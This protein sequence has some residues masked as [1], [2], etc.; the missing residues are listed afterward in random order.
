MLKNLKKYISILLTA[1]MLFTTA[2]VRPEKVSDIVGVTASAI[3]ANDE[4]QTIDVASVTIDGTTTNYTDITSA[5]TAA[6][7][8]TAYVTLLQD[9]DIGS[10][11][12]LVNNNSNLT[13]D[14][15]GYTLT[16]IETDTISIINGSL[17]VKNGTVKNTSIYAT[18]ITCGNIS[19]AMLT[20]ES[21]AVIKS[22]KGD[23]GICVEENS[24][25]NIYGTVQG[26]ETG[27][28]AKYGTLNVYPG[29][30]IS[31]DKYGIKTSAYY[32][33]NI[34]LH[35]GTICGGENAIYRDTLNK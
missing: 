33:S 26:G 18:T 9:A 25:V 29:A 5:W 10:T 23:Y 2:A 7:G 3:D 22:D 24:S 35:G 19:A 1:A 14:C 34:F 31:G 8:N 13:L 15:G 28:Y 30:V 12:L 6:N 4:T 21:S 16:G 11:K 17:T 20:V 27:V 32:E